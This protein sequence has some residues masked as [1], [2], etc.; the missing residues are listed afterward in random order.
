[1]KDVAPYIC[2]AI[3]DWKETHTLVRDMWPKG[4]NLCAAR[5]TL[6]SSSKILGGARKDSLPWSSARAVITWTTVC[7]N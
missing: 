6:V 7:V 5:Y 3:Y 1:M 2:I 4:D